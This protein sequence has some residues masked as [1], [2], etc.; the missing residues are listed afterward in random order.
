MAK[1]TVEKAVELKKE[2]EQKIKGL[3]NDYS[4]ETEIILKKI[5][6]RPNIDALNALEDG[7]LSLMKDTP[8][9]LGVDIVGEI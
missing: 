7:Q 6:V 1:I 4:Q 8:V 2:L 3:L 9:Y 5:T